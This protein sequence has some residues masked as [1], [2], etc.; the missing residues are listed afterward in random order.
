M[1]DRSTV[2]A[3]LAD[4]DP[5]VGAAALRVSEK[6]LRPG[7][8]DAEILA[9]VI[10]L[11]SG[12]EPSVRLQLALTLGEAQAPA[13]DA[14]LR[15]L[16]IVAGRQPF[17][18][19]AVVS[20]LARREAEFVE[21]LAKD[22]AA[23]TARA[24]DAV[25]FA[26]SATLKSGE[27]ARIERVLAV[28]AN[29]STPAWARSAVLSGVRL[30]LPKS[31]DGKK[32]FPGS[33]PAEPKSLMALAKTETTAGAS[34]KQL[35]AQLKWPG[36]IGASTVEARALTADEQALFEKGKAQFAQLC[37]ACHQPNGQGLAGLAPSLLYSRWVLGDPRVLAR[38][39][40]NGKVQESLSMPPWRAALDDQAIAGVLTFVRRSWG[41]DADP[42]SP[43]IVADA[44]KE[45]EKREEPWSDADLEDLVQSFAMAKK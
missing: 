7:A 43:V 42:V 37:A 27:A 35:L 41:H 34:A 2:L 18:A 22:P 1:L 17:L 15:A 21:A 10:A 40:L 23:A 25:R 8:V 32:V 26:T 13:A 33:L 4:P 12:T 20:G 36:Q 45:T 29:D 30:F 19:D 31:P 3:A 16:V 44:R 24:V 14:A 28:A 38:I 9:R 6:F 5:R 39:V 11:G